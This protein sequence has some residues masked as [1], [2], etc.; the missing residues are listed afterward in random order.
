[1]SQPGRLLV[2][3]HGNPPRIRLPAV[4]LAAPMHLSEGRSLALRLGISR[5]L[6]SRRTPRSADDRSRAIPYSNHG[7]ER[8]TRLELATLTLA[9]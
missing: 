4:F 2:L 1:M 7:V 6:L 3:A 5:H 8:E 9:R